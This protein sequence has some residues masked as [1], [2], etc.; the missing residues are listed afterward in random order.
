MRGF[1]MFSVN[2]V[3]WLE[4][5]KPV[6]GP[7]DAILRPIAVAVCTSDVHDSHGGQGPINNRI[8][9][10]ESIGEVVEV[11]SAIKRFKPGDRVIVSCVTPDWETPILQDGFNNNAHDTKTGGSFKFIYEKDGVFAEYYHVNN[12]DANLFL[13]PDDISIEDALATSDM[14]P[15]AFKGVENADIHFGESVAVYGI[16]PVGLLAVAGAALSG[17]GR[18]FAIDN[19]PACE[20]LA[21]E[22]GATEI[23]NFKKDSVRKKIFDLNHGPVD[24]VIIAG[25]D[26]KLYV[27]ALRLVRPNGII[28]NVC[29]LDCSDVVSFPAYRW[30]MGM[31]CVAIKSGACPGGARQVERMVQLI[32]SGRIHPGKIMNYKLEGFEKIEEA[33]HLM[34][35][36]PADL[37]KPYVLINW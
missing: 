7:N 5:E 20:A 1:G 27:Q 18:I 29:Y 12:A 30:G 8:L 34:E 14:M 9:G 21:R 28:S 13:M 16:G 4:K 31:S 11:G 32:Q 6:A 35:H 15:T 37:I 36:R 3:G 10:H 26:S 19:R 25:G 2:N 17:A 23:I 24:K 22:Y 33:F